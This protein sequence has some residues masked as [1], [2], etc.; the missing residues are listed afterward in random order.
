MY[1]LLANIFP[2]TSMDLFSD[3]L[4]SLTSFFY[5]VPAGKP[6]AG[7]SW[8]FWGY[9]CKSLDKSLL[10]SAIARDKQVTNAGALTPP[11]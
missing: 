3:S 9:L 2:F 5:D 7:R 4:G 8:P 1:V 6:L 11:C 10:V